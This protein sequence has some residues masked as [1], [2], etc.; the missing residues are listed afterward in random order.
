MQS[1]MHN[2]L[3]E[4]LSGRWQRLMLTGHTSEQISEW[5]RCRGRENIA[6]PRHLAIVVTQSG[7]LFLVLKVESIAVCAPM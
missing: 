1:C 3:P 5:L 4:I 7:A 2:V 6:Q